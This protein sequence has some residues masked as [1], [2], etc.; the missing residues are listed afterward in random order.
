MISDPRSCVLSRRRFLGI[1]TALAGGL[2]LDIPFATQADEVATQTGTPLL[3]GAWRQLSR[4]L[5]GTL[6]RPGDRGFPNLALPNNLRYRQIK[7]V[8]IALCEDAADISTCL[9]W[10][11]RHGVP[12]RTRGGGHSY[13][14]YSTTEGLILQ[15]I[16]GHQLH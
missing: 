3:P 14:G 5:R 1:T 4:Q 6:L 16:F 15:P 12:L 10:A 11:R 9:K 13:A 8:G 7:P 2:A